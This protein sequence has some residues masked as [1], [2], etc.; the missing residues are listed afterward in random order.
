M[1]NNLI[2]YTDGGCSGNPG[3]GGY[4]IIG[5]RGKTIVYQYVSFEDYTTNNRMELKAILHILKMAAENPEEEYFV[6][7][8]SSYA[9]QSFTNWIY[10]WAE[11]GWQN[12][13]K[14]TVENVDIM[15]EAYEYLHFPLK[16]FQLN[17]TSGHSGC[18][19]NELVDALC[20]KNI[21]K[22]NKLVRENKLVIKEE[23]EEK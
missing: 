3:P 1:S 19:G 2:F 8:D 21:S 20:T 14:K 6:Y 4:G 12:S 23:I 15:K 16:N 17:K 5:L 10:S 18:L 7:S 9:I 11:N 13:K 22:F